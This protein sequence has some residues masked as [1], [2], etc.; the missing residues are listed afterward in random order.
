MKKI[1]LALVVV[2]GSAIMGTWFVLENGNIQSHKYIYMWQVHWYPNPDLKLDEIERP[3]IPKGFTGM[4]RHY[5]KQGAVTD[6]WGPL[7]DGKL[8]GPEEG[9]TDEECVAFYVERLGD[10]T[11]RYP[12]NVH[13]YLW[14]EAREALPEFGPLAVEPLVEVILG[15]EASDFKH[16][17]ACGALEACLYHDDCMERWG[18]LIPADDRLFGEYEQRMEIWREWWGKNKGTIQNN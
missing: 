16:R 14:A 8:I 2:L 12:Y 7:K 9:A 1:Y 11:Y 5:D 4:W 15:G 17:E 13:G 18:N 6:T 3:M 10:L